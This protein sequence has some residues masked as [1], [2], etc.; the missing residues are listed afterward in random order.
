MSHVK[1]GPPIVTAKNVR[2]GYISLDDTH[3]ASEAEFASLRPKDR[4]RKGDLLIIKDGATIGRAAIVDIQ[5]PF[6][7]S[8]TVAVLW[9]ESCLLFRPFLLLVIQSPDSQKAIWAAAEGAAIPHLSITD[10][11]KMIL[12][13]PPIP[14]QKRIVTKVAEL[15]AIC[16]ELEGRLINRGIVAGA[17]IAAAT[18]SLLVSEPQPDKQPKVDRPTKLPRVNYQRTIVASPYE[19]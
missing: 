9:L 4:P 13:V 19:T 14:E 3:Y 12:P 15:L 18:H 17:L 16:D 2:D 8:Q 10:F 7:I 6:C 5:K 1:S 11:A